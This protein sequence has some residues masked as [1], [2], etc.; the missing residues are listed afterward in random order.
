MGGDVMGIFLLEGTIQNYAWGGFSFISEVLGF[1][2]NEQKIA[3]YWMG[4]HDNS[5]SQIHIEKDKKPL[6]LIIN[7]YPEQYL[8]K[9]VANKY[10]RLPYL[11][12]ILDVKDML[13]IQ[14]HPSIEEA[15]KGFEKENKAGIPIN[16]P[17]RNY[18]DQN[19]KPEIMVALSEFWLLHGFLPEE[20]LKLQLR[21][22]PELIHLV[23]VLESTGYMGLYKQV[24]TE[25]NST[26][27]ST[28][29]PLIDR[30]LPLYRENKLKKDSP[31]FWAARA[32]DTFCKEEDLD[33][34]IYSI[35][36]FNLVKLSVGEAIF[37]D[38]GVPHA[39][40]EGQ[41]IELMAN[42]DNVLRGGLTPK[43]VDVSE[44]L[45]HVQF[46]GIIPKIDKGTDNENTAL[47][48]GKKVAYECPVE[49][50]K[51]EKLEI[52][53][54]GHLKSHTNTPVI[55]IMIK[56]NSLVKTSE[57]ILKLDKGQ[58]IFISPDTAYSIE[59]IAAS[60]FYI[61]SVNL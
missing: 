45:K 13:S 9:A 33:K 31:D 17:H 53:P 32:Y 25:T 39:Y 54:E 51:L 14:V 41:N 10:G 57:Q 59:G 47:Y 21:G 24:M 37:Q 16:A 18:K 43:H 8:G 50:F 6:N 61:A 5:P 28:L 58:A 29:K 60:E 1:Q 34:G 55:L 7:E 3:E 49:D 35:Y 12:K 26:T 27:N 15:I 19:H 44:L 42:S 52:L 36:F 48:R 46:S 4:A 23:E 38:A 20:K 30:I 56:G 11:F 22:I 2:N 40:L